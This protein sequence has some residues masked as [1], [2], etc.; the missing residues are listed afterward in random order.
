MKKNIKEYLQELLDKWN[1]YDELDGFAAGSFRIDLEMLLKYWDLRIDQPKKQPEIKSDAEEAI[2]L[3]VDMAFSR[4]KELEDLEEGTI[5]GIERR[6]KEW[7]EHKKEFD[8]KAEEQLER[9]KFKPEKQEEW[10]ERLLLL[11]PCKG[12][13]GDVKSGKIKDIELSF[14]Q[15]ELLDFI[16]Q[17]LSER[18]FSKKEFE[19]VKNNLRME[20]GA[21]AYYEAVLEKIERFLSGS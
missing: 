8:K 21:E 13:I 7:K 19:Y 2:D 9:F 17:L 5:K 11:S 6:S 3:C 12:L 15:N 1:G 10:R 18:S 20:I 4:N 14:K 16:S